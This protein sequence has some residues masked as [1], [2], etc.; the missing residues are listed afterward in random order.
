MIVGVGTRYTVQHG[1]DVCVVEES[2]R[3]GYSITLNGV[4]LYRTDDYRFVQDSDPVFWALALAT[5]GLDTGT[6]EG[7]TGPQ[8]ELPAGIVDELSVLTCE[9]DG[10]SC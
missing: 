5:D 3:K 1:D 9:L 7:Y 4:E 10:E 6:G 8:I 2:T